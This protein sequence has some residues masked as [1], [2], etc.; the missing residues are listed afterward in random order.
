MKVYIIYVKSI[1]LS[2]KSS[3]CKIFLQTQDTFK[4][5]QC[6]NMKPQSKINDIK[7]LG[8]VLSKALTNNQIVAKYALKDTE[9]C[10]DCIE[11]EF[12][13]DKHY[14]EWCNSMLNEARASER[15]RIAYAID[16]IPIRQR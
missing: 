1:K 5:F 6:E 15:E 11:G 3:G 2:R 9:G 7:L 10:P 13:C 8:K 4:D 14:D 16:R 12:T